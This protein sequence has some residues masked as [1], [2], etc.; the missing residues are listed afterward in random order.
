MSTYHFVARVDHAIATFPSWPQAMSR[1]AG[2]LLADATGT[3]GYWQRTVLG[4]VVAIFGLPILFY[5][6]THPA[7]LRR[8][9]RSGPL[10]EPEPSQRII[11]VLFLLAILTLGIVSALD[12]NHGWST[13]PVFVVLLGDL[14][15]AG[16][17][18]LVLFVFRANPFAASTVTVEQGQT[19]ISTGPYAF[20]RHPMYSGLLSVLLGLPLALGSWWGLLIFPLLVAILIFRLRDEE[21]YLAEHLPGYREYCSRVRYRLVPG[22][23]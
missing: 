14:L 7:L 17:L 6:L 22:V 1:Q 13:V 2:N 11:V 20:V 9:L 3:T 12:H 4:L 18:V 16:G 21:R 23:W 15:V 5:V 8:R 19:V 10:A